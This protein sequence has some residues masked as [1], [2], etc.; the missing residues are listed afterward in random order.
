VHV[1][2]ERSGNLWY[3]SQFPD[4]PRV[5]ETQSSFDALWSGQAT[6]FL[7]ADQ[8]DPREL[9]GTERHVL[10]RSGGKLILTNH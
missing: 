10:A 5:F 9:H 4:A 8:E 3:G 7:W 6:V 1:L 2:H